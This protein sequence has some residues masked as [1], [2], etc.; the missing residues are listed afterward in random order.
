MMNL[1]GLEE[2]SA[3]RAAPIHF[4]SSALIVGFF[5]LLPLLRL[6]LSLTPIFVGASSSLSSPS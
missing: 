5:F 1:E 3:S 2:A 4:S 6:K